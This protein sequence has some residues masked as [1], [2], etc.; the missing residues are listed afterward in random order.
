MKSLD[1]LDINYCSANSYF[2]VDDIKRI[3]LSAF[4]KE[5][6]VFSKYGYY[7]ILSF[8]SV[9]FIDLGIITFK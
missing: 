7:R 5:E 6:E 3:N 9:I 2:N 1:R 8:I 4:D